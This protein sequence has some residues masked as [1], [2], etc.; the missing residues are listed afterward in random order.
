MR[1]NDT[2]AVLIDMQEK[3]VPRIEG[4]KEIVEN[5]KKLL[6][7]FKIFKIPIIATEQIKLGDTI[8]DLKN[9]IDGKVTKSS[10]SCMKEKS[11][12]DTIKF[13]DRKRCVLLGIE[14]HICVLQT[15]IDMLKD[16]EVLVAVDCTGSRKRIDKEVALLR[17]HK[18]G[19][20]LTTAE[21]IIYEILESAENENFKDILPIV[22]GNQQ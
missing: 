5:S 13:L 14:T 2:F 21:T 8:P 9:L 15:A 6:K 3:L 7:A 1:K 12:V 17:L 16:Y 20:I 18:Q 11:F 4:I 19:V 22:K 10:F